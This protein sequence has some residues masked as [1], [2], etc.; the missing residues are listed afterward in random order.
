MFFEVGV[1]K[2]DNSTSNTSAIFSREV[3]AIEAIPLSTCDKK[4][5][6]RSAFSLNCFKV[7]P[8]E[9]RNS[10][11]FLPISFFMIPPSFLIR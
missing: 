1:K 6:E 4:L 10:L 9:F 11:I 3:T 7:K 8:R 2:Y 5:I